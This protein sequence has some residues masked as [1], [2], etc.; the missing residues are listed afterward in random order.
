M[1]TK[2]IAVLTSPYVVVAVSSNVT[3]TAGVPDPLAPVWMASASLGSMVALK[4]PRLTE[5]LPCMSNRV[6]VLAGKHEINLRPSRAG[7]SRTC[8]TDHVTV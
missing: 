2:Y 5:T 8:S 4:Y 3:A 1:I 7:A 6:R